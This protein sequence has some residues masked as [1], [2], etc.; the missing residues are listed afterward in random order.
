MQTR[1]GWIPDMNS[2]TNQVA[3]EKL[4]AKGYMFGNVPIRRF[5]DVQFIA[6]DFPPAELNVVTQQLKGND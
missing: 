4:A 3:E 5:I 6:H 2:P 1:G